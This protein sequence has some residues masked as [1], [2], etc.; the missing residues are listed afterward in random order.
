[1]GKPLRLVDNLMFIG[2][3]KHTIDS[4]KRLALPAKFR[5]KLGKKV[6]ITKGVDKCLVVYPEKEWNVMSKKLEKLPIS[7]KEARNF[8]R[9]MLAG[10]VLAGID[11]LGR[12]LIP[13]YLKDYATLKK[14]TVVCGLS[15]RLE[16]WDEKKWNSFKSKIEPKVDDMASNL[17]ELGI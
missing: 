2:E 8:A 6:V 11:R 7:R 13:D 17:E 4:K 12:V 15:N 5:K 9:I 16:I 3:Y 1:M 10:A 14:N